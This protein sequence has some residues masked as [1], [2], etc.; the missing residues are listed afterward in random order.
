MTG[1]FGATGGRT[2]PAGFVG[3]FAAVVDLRPVL[4]G[5]FR[6]LVGISV[7]LRA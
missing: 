2:F 1:F 3:R 6:L 4:R 5:G 7:L